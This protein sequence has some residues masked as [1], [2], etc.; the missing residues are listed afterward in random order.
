M[1][2]PQL[3]IKLPEG[4]DYVLH[5]VFYPIILFYSGAQYNALFIEDASR[6]S[7]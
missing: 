1:F 5:S 4:L 3:N 6:N 2:A 7:C